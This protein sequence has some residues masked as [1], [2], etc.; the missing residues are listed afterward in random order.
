[1]SLQEFPDENRRGFLANFGRC[2]DL[3]NPPLFIITTRSAIASASFWSW[4][5]KRVLILSSRWS[6]FTQVRN[7][8][9]QGA[10]PLAQAQ[11]DWH[12]LA[13]NVCVS[14]SRYTVSQRT[15]P[16]TCATGPRRRRR[17]DA[18]SRDGDR[19]DDESCPRA[20]FQRRPNDARARAYTELSGS[21]NAL[22]KGNKKRLSYGFSKELKKL[23]A[24][25]EE[26]RQT[27]FFE[28]PK[29]GEVQALLG[30]AA[31]CAMER[32]PCPSSPRRSSQAERGSRDP[33]RRLIVSAP[34][35]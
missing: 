25:F 21:L 34:P 1:M 29:A 22:L 30:N 24:R 8:F 32:P 10:M 17:C 23:N 15:F 26:I 3:L 6:W 28:C 7:S 12:V 31:A 16:I 5:T 4:V 14:P 9:P 20:P 33:A 11:E 19:G 27:D 35:G 13:E 18:D 2:A